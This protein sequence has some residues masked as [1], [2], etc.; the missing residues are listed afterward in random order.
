MSFTSIQQFLVSRSL[1]GVGG[2]TMLNVKTLAQKIIYTTQT[3]NNN[4]NGHHKYVL[5]IWIM[6]NVGKIFLWLLLECHFILHLFIFFWTKRV[7]S[8]SSFLP[9][10]NRVIFNYEKITKNFPLNWLKVLEAQTLCAL[11]R[12]RQNYLLSKTLSADFY[13][14]FVHCEMSKQLK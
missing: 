13:L 3:T 8:Y 2:V 9:K 14:H 10:L 6:C 5:V 11:R 1:F 7:N 12:H 4:N